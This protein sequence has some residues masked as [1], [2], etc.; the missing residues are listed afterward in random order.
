MSACTSSSTCREAP[1]GSTADRK[2][3][4]RNRGPGKPGPQQAAWLANDASGSLK[5]KTGIISE[6][7][8]QLDLTRYANRKSERKQN[9]NCGFDRSM[10]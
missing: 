9:Y 8:A 5:I 7:S 4:K 6:I 2:V 10:T 3:D 1:H